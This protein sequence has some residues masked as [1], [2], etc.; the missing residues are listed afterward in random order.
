MVTFGSPMILHSDDAPAMYAALEAL[1]R[2]AQRPGADLRVHNC[3]NNADVVPR[4]LGPQLDTM[5][6]AVH[7]M[8]PSIEVWPS[9][10]KPESFKSPGLHCHASSQEPHNTASCSLLL[11]ACALTRRPEAYM[12]TDSSQDCR[13]IA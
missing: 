13:T 10:C 12:L 8:M 11:P 1:G 3:V 6:E 9:S 4:A 2:R 7:S 5:Y